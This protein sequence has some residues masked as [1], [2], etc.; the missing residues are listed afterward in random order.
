[1]APGA[2]PR[3]A[4]PRGTS[5]C[6]AM[7]VSTTWQGRPMDAP[8]LA[9][10][11]Y[12]AY[13]ARDWARAQACLHPDAEVAMLATSERLAGR[14]QVIRF[15]R[16]FPEPWG[17]LAVLRALGDAARPRPSRWKSAPGTG[18]SGWPPSGTCGTA[19]WPAAPSTGWTPAGARRPG[20]PLTRPLRRPG[21]DPPR[22]GCPD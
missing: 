12:T 15:Q 14:E 1:M 17:E 11:L 21:T 10:A 18:C 20:G 3:T 2:Q 22:P 8:D 7:G 19:C 4:S 9:R 13:Q 16:E 6:L 5:P